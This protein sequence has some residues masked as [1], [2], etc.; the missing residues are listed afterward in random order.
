M[1]TTAVERDGG[2][3][4]NGTKTWIT[5]GTVADVAIV[6]ARCEDGKIRGFLVE[7]GTKGFSARDIEG[8]FSLRASVTSELVLQDCAIPVANL[9]PR[10]KGLRSALMCLN[11]ARYGIAW[12]GIGAAQAVFEESLSFARERIVFGKP[13]AAF[14]L[15]QEKLVWMASEITKAQLLALRLGRMKDEWKATPEQ[16]SMGKRNNVWVA[17]E[18]ARL[19]REILGAVGIMDEYQTGRHMCNIESVYT[20]EGTHDIHSLVVGQE[21]TGFSAFE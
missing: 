21:I 5:N 11:Q 8:K 12:G 7:R 20:Y 10:S 17:R 19:A 9:L 18:S 1:R 3:V 15:Q 13:V 14:Q 4:L 2:Y 6:W 16:I